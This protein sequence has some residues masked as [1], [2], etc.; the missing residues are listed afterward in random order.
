[1][2]YQT[3]KIGIYTYT[4]KIKKGSKENVESHSSSWFWST[5]SQNK[6]HTHTHNWSERSDYHTDQKRSLKI[7]E[8]EYD[9]VDIRE[10]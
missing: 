2:I 8:S 1:M 5:N 10:T 7:L 4:Y 6:T 9:V 3:C